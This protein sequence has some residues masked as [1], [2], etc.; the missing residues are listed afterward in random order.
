MTVRI[1]E[2]ES[3]LPL[4]PTFS[5]DGYLDF[6]FTEVDGVTVSHL[7]PEQE[8]ESGTG[9]LVDGVL[10]YKKTEVK[11]VKKLPDTYMYDVHRKIDDY[12]NYKDGKLNY[13]DSEDLKEAVLKFVGEYGCWFANGNDVGKPFYEP[14]HVDEW[15]SEWGDV[16]D[17]VKYIKHKYSL[18]DAFGSDEPPL[19]GVTE[20]KPQIIED[21]LN[22]YT[23]IAIAPQLWRKGNS[24]EK[25]STYIRPM[26][27]A[28]WVW[29]LIAK[30]YYDETTYSPCPKP[31]CTREI[32]SV[33]PTSG[34][35]NLKYCSESCRNAVNYKRR[36]K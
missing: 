21:K 28:G 15:R 1:L 30:D 17:A 4:G 22:E 29:A 8:Y 2:Y 33:S 10:Y 3:Y 24:K 25:F 6:A 36:T 13:L 7:P 19:Q 31:N 23:T 34:K 18:T 12:L 20:L 9:F 26:C 32:P 5:E 27:I 35:G 16:V 11:T 14:H